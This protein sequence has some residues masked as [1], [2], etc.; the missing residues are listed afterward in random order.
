[1]R[2]LIPSHLLSHAALVDLVKVAGGDG[3]VGAGVGQL[4]RL[5]AND[6]A[7]R[8]EAVLDEACGGKKK[9]KGVAEGEAEVDTDGTL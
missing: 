3:E 8:L 5:V 2:G 6:G 9:I 7:E 4:V 1:M